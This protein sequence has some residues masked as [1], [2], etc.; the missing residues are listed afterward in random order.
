[1]AV[2]ERLAREGVLDTRNAAEAK[3]YTVTRSAHAA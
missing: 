3:R 1:M 2:L